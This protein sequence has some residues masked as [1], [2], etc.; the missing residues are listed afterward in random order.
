MGFYEAQEIVLYCFLADV[1]KISSL[2]LFISNSGI[3]LQEVRKEVGFRQLWIRFVEVLQSFNGT[4]AVSIEHIEPI[5][6]ISL[7]SLMKCCHVAMFIRA[8]HGATLCRLN[9]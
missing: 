6:L 5:K 4:K 2:T 8:V 3:S 1:L 9:L 7:I